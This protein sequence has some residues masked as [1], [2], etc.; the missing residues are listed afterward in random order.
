MRNHTSRRQVLAT[1][2]IGVGVSISGCL[3]GDLLGGGGGTGPPTWRN[4]E[5]SPAGTRHQP[6]VSGPDSAPTEAW[7]FERSGDDPNYPILDHG[8]IYLYDGGAAIALDGATGEEEWRALAETTG[9]GRT[10]A[11]NGETVL[12][13]NDDTIVA[14]DPDS[15]DVRWRNEDLSSPQLSRAAG[16][17]VYVEADGV[18]VL[19]AGSGEERWNAETETSLDQIGVGSNGWVYGLDHDSVVHGIDGGGRIQWTNDLTAEHSPG[20]SVGDGRVYA[21]DDDQEDLRALDARTGEQLW[22]TE[23]DCN[24]VPSYD[25]DAVYVA[26]HEDG[27]KKFDPATGEVAD[28]WEGGVLPEASGDPVTTTDTVLVW[29]EGREVEDDIEAADLVAL[30]SST[31]AERWRVSVPPADWHGSI[32]VGD[33][34]LYCMLEFG[35][36]AYEV[37]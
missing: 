29:E 26:G 31:A 27:V 8:R 20:I 18:T 5:G 34:M 21:T 17:R 24:N 28:A 25:G 11:S 35:V 22:E 7:R 4:R 6:A 16:D 1:G 36:V 30:D 2:A 12:A 19:D 14:L 9:D 33:G 3:G 37:A 10:L 15:G 23:L 13:E 32:L